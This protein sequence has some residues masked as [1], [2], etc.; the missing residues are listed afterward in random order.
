MI[1]S[2]TAYA[3]RFPSGETCTLPIRFTDI[4]ISEVQRCGSF[5]FALGWFVA[6]KA[7]STAI[8][9]VVNNGRET[10]SRKAESMKLI[11]VLV[12]TRVHSLEATALSSREEVG[13]SGNFAR[14][15]GSY[16]EFFVVVTAAAVD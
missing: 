10:I 9:D 4:I 14:R 15:L 6:I 5:A 16:A 11:N 12:L 7:K 1:A 8:A 2:R 3:T 13:A